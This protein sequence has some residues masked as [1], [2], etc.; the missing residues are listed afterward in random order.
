VSGGCYVPTGIEASET[1]QKS[2][3]CAKTGAPRLRCDCSK[4]QFFVW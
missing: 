2:L 4:L 3:D 1:E